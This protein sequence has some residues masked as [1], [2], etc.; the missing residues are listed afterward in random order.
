MIIGTWDFSKFSKNKDL[1]FIILTC[2]AGNYYLAFFIFINK[3]NLSN[4]IKE[5][6]DDFE[7]Q[8]YRNMFNSLQEGVFVVDK[9]VE[10]EQQG[11]PLHIYFA[12]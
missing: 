2:F 7:F 8:N 6:V 1:A 4:I 3:R 10:E 12:N 11:E 5:E 9:A